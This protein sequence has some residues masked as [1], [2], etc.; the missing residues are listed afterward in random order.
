MAEHD[1]SMP[2]LYRNNPNTK[3]N[4]LLRNRVWNKRATSNNLRRN[5]GYLRNLKSNL[6][7]SDRSNEHAPIYSIRSPGPSK[8]RKQDGNFYSNANFAQTAPIRSI[9]PRP[10]QFK[11]FNDTLDKSHLSK[12]H[13]E[14]DSMLSNIRPSRSNSNRSMKYRSEYEAGKRPFK[15]ILRL[16]TKKQSGGIDLGL[17]AK[18]SQFGNSD[19]TLRMNSFSQSRSNV[20]DRRRFHVQM[21]PSH[22]IRLIQNSSSVNVKNKSGERPKKVSFKEKPKVIFVENWKILNVDMSKEGKLYNRFNRG[23]Q[24]RHGK[25]GDESCR[26]F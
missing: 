7:M 24:G 20:R 15:S 9:S 14:F 26:V 18:R 4:T 3:A 5:Q 22:G 2:I 19:D 1:K 23:K 10:N 11:I 25:A 6:D 13:S 16:K 8:N 21:K 17:H 12:A